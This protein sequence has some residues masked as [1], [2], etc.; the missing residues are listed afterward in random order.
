MR[1]LLYGMS[2]GLFYTAIVV[3]MAACGLSKTQKSGVATF[4]EAAAVLG[5]ASKANFQ[6]GRENVIQM[7][8]QR[9]AI[10][11]KTLPA[12][13]PDG[14]A[15]DRAFYTAELNLDS[16]LDPANI[17]KRV[18]ASDLLI[19]YGKLLVAFSNENQEQEM[20]D[21]A[22]DLADSIRKFPENPLSKDEI[23]GLGKLV[24]ALGNMQVEHEKKETLK[25][26]V[27]S[28][29]RL[30][31]RLCDNLE[32]D[33]DLGKRGVAADIYNVQERLANESIDGLKR[34]GGSIAD[35]LV[36]ING[37]AMADDSRTNLQGASANL[38]KAVASLRQ[39]EKKLSDQI[40]NN[41][42]TFDEIKSFAKDAA[43]LAKA[44]KPFAK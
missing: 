40:D 39:A 7:K 12:V 37:F 1:K 33:F 41:K 38:L 4:G 32:N 23:D 16:G 24:L 30:I 11:R 6:G 25:T 22:A 8:K 26:I 9:L 29:S 10:E 14:T 42:F 31:T 5:T 3:S 43:N 27:P 44:I 13:K 19:Q 36:L 20:S 18:N 2:R 28:M 34:E 21:S 35:R 17:E 15:P